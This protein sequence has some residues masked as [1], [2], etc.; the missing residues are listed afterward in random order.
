LIRYALADEHVKFLAQVE[1]LFESSRSATVS[2][3][4]YGRIAQKLRDRRVQP[5]V[6]D[7]ERRVAKHDTFERLKLES[8]QLARDASNRVHQLVPRVREFIFETAFRENG[9]RPTLQT[10]DQAIE[11]ALELETSQSAIQLLSDVHAALLEV[12]Q[13]LIPAMPQPPD[14]ARPVIEIPREV[15]GLPHPRA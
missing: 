8:G 15:L 10:L 5:W 3:R 12:G 7:Q 14:G 1:K 9:L 11:S 6:L 4:R 13:L 2:A